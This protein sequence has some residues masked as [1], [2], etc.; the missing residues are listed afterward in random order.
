MRKII[1]SPL[2]ARIKLFCI[3]TL[4][5]LGLSLSAQ[6]ILTYTAE[7]NLG[8][9]V[10]LDH[11][12]VENLTQ[13]W[14]DTLYFP[15]T[16]LYMS[17]VGIEDYLTD[18]PFSITPNIPNPFEGSTSFS[19]TLP[20][21]DKVDLMVFDISGRRVLQKSQQLDRGIHHF[22][23]SL[24]APQTY[25]LTVRTSKDQASIKMLNQGQ[26]ESNHIEHQGST[27]LSTHLKGTRNGVPSFEDGDLIRSTGYALR[28]DDTMFSSTIEQTQN[29]GDVVSFIFE[30][31]ETAASATSTGTCFIPDGEDCGQGCSISK[32]F[33]FNQFHPGATI[34]SAEDIQYVRLK[35]EH[36]RIGDLNIRL[37]C[38]N[39]QYVDLLS[40]S[41]IYT[42]TL[43]PCSNQVFTLGTGWHATENA[44][45]DAHLGLFNGND[46][47]DA[48]DT[49]ANPIGVC[50]N[51]C[52][53]ESTIN[54]Y[55]YACGNAY[56]YEDCNHISAPN[57]YASTT[58]LYVDSTDVANMV[59]VYHPDMHFTNLIE[60]PM[61]GVWSIKVIDYSEEMNGYIEEMEVA[62]QQSANYKAVSFSQVSKQTNSK[63]RKKR[64]REN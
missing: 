46:G 61:N 7:D 53:S 33:L 11:V 14:T 13:N 54:G 41:P 42:P 32:F 20:Y 51:Y 45:I 55:Q 9:Y 43:S 16:I 36:E 60:C 5:F 31:Y 57:P 58:S 40:P 6:D 17:G 48:C 37:T 56:V 29:I 18:I 28:Y 25:L 63:N 3:N 39:G 15:D 27:P 49:A 1:A 21:Q 35:M 24:S 30:L 12:V 50:W 26:Y 23:V 52:W 19:V 62:L 59:N 4:M 64:I 38:P 44:S 22:Q 47:V 8:D 34:Q 10:Q 2:E